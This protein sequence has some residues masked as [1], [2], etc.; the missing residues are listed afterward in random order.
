MEPVKSFKLKGD[1]P[2]WIEK[3]SATNL[4][5]QQK[6]FSETKFCIT[7]NCEESKFQ[8][9]H[10]IPGASQLSQIA[11]SGKVCWIPMRERDRWRLHAFFWSEAPIASTLVFRGFCNKCDN[12]IF[13]KI[14]TSLSLDQE[15]IFLLAYR[16]FSYYNWRFEVDFNSVKNR[17]RIMKEMQAKNPDIPKLKENFGR[18]HQSDVDRLSFL[19]DDYTKMTKYMQNALNKKITIL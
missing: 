17:K 14:D 7:P 15:T 6:A 2:A 4:L 13:Q 5:A 8:W 1:I 11:E 16:A 12:R 18:V 19:K 9:C 3:L 10:V